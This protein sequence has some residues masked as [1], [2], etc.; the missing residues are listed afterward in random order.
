VAVRVEA[1]VQIAKPPAEMWAAIVDPRT[2][3]VT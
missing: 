3:T 2:L 1:S